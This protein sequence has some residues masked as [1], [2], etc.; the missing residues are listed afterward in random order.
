VWRALGKRGFLLL[1]IKGIFF[2]R[3]SFSPPSSPSQ[4]T[5]DYNDDNQRNIRQGSGG[6][7]VSPRGACRCDC[8]GEQGEISLYNYCRVFFAQGGWASWTGLDIFWLGLAAM[9][10]LI[11]GSSVGFHLLIH[12]YVWS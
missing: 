5:S 2:Y 8:P 1:D 6:G 7:V 11:F 10:L 3:A 9:S 12:E 4:T